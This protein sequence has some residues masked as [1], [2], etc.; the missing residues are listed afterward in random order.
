MKRCIEKKQS[1]KRKFVWH[2]KFA[3]DDDL[4]DYLNNILSEDGSLS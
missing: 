4:W 2:N 1:L 3:R